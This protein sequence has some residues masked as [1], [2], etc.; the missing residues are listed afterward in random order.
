M[1]TP[2][3]ELVKLKDLK[4]LDD[5]REI[6]HQNTGMVISF[7]YPGRGDQWDF[8]PKKQKNE[9]CSIIQSTEQGMARCL[10]SDRQGLARARK[11]NSYCM[12]R[13]HASLTDVSIP[14]IYEGS[15]LGAIYTGQVMLEQQTNDSF[16]RLFNDL[17]DLNLDYDRLKKAYFKVKVVPRERLSFYVKLLT[18][19]ANYIVT[20]EHEIQLQRMVINKDREIY[21]KER[22]RMK[23]EK[24]L[25]DLTISVLELEQEEHGFGGVSDESLKNSDKVAKAQDFIRRNFNRNIRLNDVATAVY[26]SPNYFSSLFRKITGNTFSTYLMKL[27]VKAAREL[28]MQSDTPIKEIVHQVGF[29]DYNYFNRTFKR[30]E[31]MP[32]A[33]FRQINSALLRQRSVS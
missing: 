18:L 11:R 33:R 3:Q 13:C 25:S 24:A 1:G 28:L 26:L 20:V 8:F 14:L 32:P 5:M 9:F 23:L 6:Y 12:Y 7:H 27:R 19:I 22:E 2:Y 17:R 31:G 21:R 4:I 15:E 29:E 16:N 10:D 30:I